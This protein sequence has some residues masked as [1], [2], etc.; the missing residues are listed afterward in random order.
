VSASIAVGD[1]PLDVA[2]DDRSVWVANAGSGTVS[3]IDPTRN[4][5]VQ[6]P[7]VGNGPQSIATET[8]CVW[9]PNALDGTVAQL[10]ATTGAITRT[11][12]AGSSPTSVTLAGGSR[13]SRKD[14]RVDR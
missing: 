6:Q 5:E 12:D 10:D 14:R 4:V 8:G 1:R 2:I 9:S 3:Q 11:V 7:P 13:G